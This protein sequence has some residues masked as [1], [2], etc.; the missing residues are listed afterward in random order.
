MDRELEEMFS[1]VRKRIRAGYTVIMQHQPHI[2]PQVWDVW[3]SIAS[4]WPKTGQAAQSHGRHR[5]FK[6]ALQRALKALDSRK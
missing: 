1:E 2:T 3:I 6:V 5:N 4:G